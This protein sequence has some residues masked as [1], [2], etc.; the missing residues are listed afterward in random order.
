MEDL[1]MALVLVLAV[2][3]VESLV[4]RLQVLVRCLAH[5]LVQPLQVVQ[6]VA[7]L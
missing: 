7:L 1:V 2:L 4:P 3:L 5:S 6:V